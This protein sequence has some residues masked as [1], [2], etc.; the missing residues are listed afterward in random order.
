MAKTIKNKIY[1][2]F[3]EDDN[4]NI[5]NEKKTNVVSSDE[6]KKVEEKLNKKVSSIKKEI[7]ELKNEN[8]IK[9]V[10]PPRGWHA[11]SEF[12]DEI[13]NKFE[14]GIY[15]G[16]IQNKIIEEKAI[17]EKPKEIIEE[18]AIEEKAIEEKIVEEKPKEKIK[19]KINLFTEKYNYQQY[20]N[21]NEPFKI[22][23]R[24]TLIF[25]SKQQPLKNYPIFQD[26]NFILFGK[27][28]LYRGIKIEKY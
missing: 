10:N 14:K 1:N 24:G 27:T 18:K 23:F 21:D 22:F 16:K 9:P 7:K 4:L 28:Y 6:I 3:W 5:K 20:I 8:E 11:R 26:N 2:E 15:V 19:E 25:D 13:G 17:E 12:I